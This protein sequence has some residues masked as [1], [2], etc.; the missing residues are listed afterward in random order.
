MPR[1]A[2]SGWVP[3]RNSVI[4]PVLSDH[5]PH[6]GADAFTATAGGGRRVEVVSAF[7]PSNAAPVG[8]VTIRIAAYGTDEC[9]HLSISPSGD[10]ISMRTVVPSMSGGQGSDPHAGRSAGAR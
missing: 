1:M 6:G 8:P 5:I 3:L 2:E 9:V 4:V 7:S 10:A